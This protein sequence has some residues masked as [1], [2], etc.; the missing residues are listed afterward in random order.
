MSTESRSNTEND[1]T[2][3]NYLCKLL[4]PSALHVAFSEAHVAFS[5]AASWLKQE[6]MKTFGIAGVRISFISLLGSHPLIRM[7][8]EP[9]V[10]LGQLALRGIPLPTLSKS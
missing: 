2:L 1:A 5:E 7:L 3:I 9:L 4:T 6:A 8:C 10:V